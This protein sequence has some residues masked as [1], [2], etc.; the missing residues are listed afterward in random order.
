MLSA[1]LTVDLPSE[2]LTTDVDPVEWLREWIG[3][4]IA[5]REALTVSP[6]SLVEGITGAFG[7]ADVRDVVALEVDGTPVYVDPEG[8]TNDR[9]AAVDAAEARGVFERSFERMWMAFSTHSHG[10]H[11]LFDSSVVREVERGAA[12]MTVEVGARADALRRGVDETAAGY[13][14]RVRAALSTSEALG[15]ARGAVDR[16]CAHLADALERTLIGGTVQVERARIRIIEPTLDELRAV[17]EAADPTSFAAARIGDGRRG[18]V[19]PYSRYFDDPMDALTRWLMV[20]AALTGLFRDPHVDVVDA[21]G[22]RLF[23]AMAPDPARCATAGAVS[24]D[25]PGGVR[26]RDDAAC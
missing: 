17:A 20:D 16:L 15:D 19:D 18:H 26:V 1:R 7:R 5:V 14:A 2:S 23:D 12:E 13:A 6:F 8:Q 11:V 24:F 3:G 25:A 22:E 10:L 4:P 21:S 9:G